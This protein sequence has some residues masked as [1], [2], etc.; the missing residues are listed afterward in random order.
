M[1][2]V[3]LKLGP[4][5]PEDAASIVNTGGIADMEKMLDDIGGLLT[6]EAQMAFRNQGWRGGTAWP[7]RQIPNVAGIVRDLERGGQPK[8]RR[9]QDVE[10]LVDTGR[11]RGSFNHRIDLEALTV[12]VSTEVPYA[13][14]M[15]EGG[16]SGP[17]LGAAKG[18]KIRAPLW[19]F[20][21][22]NV[23]WKK[24]LGWLFGVKTWSY[25]E[26]PARPL[27]EA[28]KPV[29]DDIRETVRRH[30]FGGEASE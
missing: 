20:L 16:K 1:A 2:K 9:F 14:T 3:E 23:Q 18:S 6:S 8:R 10:T 22:A 4:L 26:L 5:D 28:T 13:S 19:R 27:V 24:Q 21:K 29:I 15:H 30:R 11:L 12:T 7:P 17:F 25:K